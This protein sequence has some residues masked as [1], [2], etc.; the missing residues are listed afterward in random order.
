V[1]G[2]VGKNVMGGV[3]LRVIGDV[4][5]FGRLKIGS[6]LSRPKWQSE[7]TKLEKSK[8]KVVF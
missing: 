1:I 7:S 6:F 2:D 3:V 5:E 8:T 4:A